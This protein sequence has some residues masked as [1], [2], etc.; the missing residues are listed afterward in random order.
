MC[1]HQMGELWGQEYWV[2]Q[3]YATQQYRKNQI[4]RLKIGDGTVIQDRDLKAAALWTSY[5]DR[6]GQYE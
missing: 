4:A 6:L 3:A 5:K 2:F 1:H